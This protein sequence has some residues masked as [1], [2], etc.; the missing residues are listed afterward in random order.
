VHRGRTA[1]VIGVL[2]EG[3]CYLRLDS[4]EEYLRLTYRYVCVCVLNLFMSVQDQDRNMSE[5]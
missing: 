5:L 4:I 2:N 3:E 1:V